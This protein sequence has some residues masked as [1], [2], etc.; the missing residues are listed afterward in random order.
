MNWTGPVSRTGDRSVFPDRLGVAIP[1]QS[2]VDDNPFQTG[3]PSCLK[4]KRVSSAEDDRPPM[5]AAPAKPLIL[6]GA[7]RALD[8][9]SRRLAGVDA[10]RCSCPG[11]STGEIEES[12][13]YGDQSMQGFSF[14][15]SVFKNSG[16]VEMK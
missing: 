3:L 5:P 6:N 16:F 12:G 13:A 14:A 1:V 7:A 10:L 9:V 4:D 2:D 15:A 11:V 8:C